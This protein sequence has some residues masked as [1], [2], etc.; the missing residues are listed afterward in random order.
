LSIKKFK[1]MFANSF[2][3]EETVF[4]G[5]FRFAPVSS[6][7]LR[8]APVSCFR[9]Q[10]VFSGSVCSV[11]SVNAAGQ[12]A[13]HHG[14]GLPPATGGASV[15]PVQ[16]EGNSVLAQGATHERQSPAE[17]V[18]ESGVPHLVCFGQHAPLCQ[19]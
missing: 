15:G 17:V 2:I 12:A 5:F 6:G 16:E 7:F 10:T 19:W 8:F 1:K 18:Q 14:H 3:R 9:L 13:G 4:S 11:V